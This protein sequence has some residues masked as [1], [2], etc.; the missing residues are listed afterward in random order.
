MVSKIREGGTVPTEQ[1]EVL[2][3]SA[4]DVSDFDAVSVGYMPYYK[5]F[6]IS[7]VYKLKAFW[8]YNYLSENFKE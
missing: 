2:E 7:P 6:K 4:Y 1:K 8:E 5:N 3:S